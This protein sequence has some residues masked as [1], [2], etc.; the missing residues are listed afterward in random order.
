MKTMLVIFHWFI[1]MRLAIPQ[2]RQ[3][4]FVMTAMRMLKQV[5]VDMILLKVA[6]I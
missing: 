6:W 3:A 2:L 5:L 4:K 1:A